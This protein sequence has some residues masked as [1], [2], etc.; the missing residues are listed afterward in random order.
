M[1]L[2][3]TTVH[4]APGSDGMY[5]TRIEDATI[6]QWLRV[7][8][9]NKA[10]LILNI[11]PGRADFLDELKAYKRWL[12]EPDVGVALDPEWAVDAGQIPGRVFGNTSGKELNACA[13]WLADLVAQHQLP[14]K[15]MIYHQ[16][17]ANI[18]RKESALKPHH[19]IVLVKSIDGIGAPGAKVATWKRIIKTT[20]RFVHPGFKL[21]YQED[22]ATG[23]RLMTATE[24]LALKPRPEYVLFE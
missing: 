17:H 6:K 3:A 19:G 7:A 5:R 13:T 12:V 9:A 1:E 21:F 24:V 23:G 22:V 16:L 14:E 20:P 15:V 18:V 2:I 10:L 8:R 11:Q 4:G